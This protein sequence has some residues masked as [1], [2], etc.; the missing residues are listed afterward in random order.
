MDFRILPA[1]GQQ[2]HAEAE[3]LTVMFVQGGEGAK[4]TASW[5]INPETTRRAGSFSTA[6]L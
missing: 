4:D 3:L 6:Y 2:K 1:G 5:E